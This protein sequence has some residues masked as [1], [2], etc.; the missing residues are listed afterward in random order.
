MWLARPV[1]SNALIRTFLVVLLDCW[2]FAA[3]GRLKQRLP[4]LA[5]LLLLCC[6]LLPEG[7]ALRTVGLTE[8]RSCAPNGYEIDV[9]DDEAKCSCRDS[10]GS[11]EPMMA[12]PLRGVRPSY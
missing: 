3:A 2:R 9:V 4:W 7:G 8:K 10:P 5:M 11:P 12:E 6:C 1:F